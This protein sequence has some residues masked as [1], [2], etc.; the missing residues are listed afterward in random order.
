MPV[1]HLY[2]KDIFSKNSEVCY[3]FSRT[4]NPFTQLHDHDFYE[5]TIVTVGSV[6]HHIND[7]SE[8]VPCNTLL[9]IRPQD[10]HSFEKHPS[11]DFEYINL[12]FPQRILQNLLVFLDNGFDIENFRTVP[13]APVVHLLPSDILTIRKNVEKLSFFP[14][15]D[16]IKKKTYFRLLIAE[17]FFHYLQNAS[18][19]KKR[20]PDWFDELLHQINEPDYFSQGVAAFEILSGKSLA[21]ISRIFKEYLQTTPTNYIN[22]LRLH[23]CANYLIHSDTDIIDIAMDAGFHNLSHFYHLFK[24]KYNTSPSRYRKENRTFI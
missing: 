23:Y 24:E 13:T 22:E 19:Q 5:I 14:E 20:Y 1:S 4:K 17:L 12:A 3:S 16:N 21:Y 8:V 10:V 11:N 9:F 2:A 15:E 18:K 6:I 7:T